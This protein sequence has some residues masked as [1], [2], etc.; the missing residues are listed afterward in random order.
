MAVAAVPDLRVV[1]V[2]SRTMR[3]ARRR[4]RQTGGTA[5]T[6]DE[7]PGGANAVVVATPPAQ[8]RR[9]AERAVAAGAVALVEAP[10]AATLEDADRLVASAG[11]RVGYAEALVHSPVVIEAVAA[12]RRLGQLTHLEV[13][14]AQGRP[15]WGHHLDPSWG[16]GALLDPGVHA[17]ALTLLTAAPARL[18]RVQARPLDGHGL[19]VDDDASLTLEFDSGLRAQVRATWRAAAP[20]WDAQAAS[21]NGAVRLELVPRP[22][23]ELNGAPLALPAPPPGVA[24]PQLHHLGY[25]TQL[26][27]LAADVDAGRPPTP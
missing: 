18:R 21:P 1:R 22:T 25:V 12:C 24:S 15:D 23:V 8:H 2:A 27:A 4:T 11:R 16:G 6:Y 3:S 20:A 26:S 5:C 7:L 19:E 17:V 13:R 14:L 9:E 10:L